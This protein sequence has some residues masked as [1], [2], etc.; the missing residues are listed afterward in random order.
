MDTKQFRLPS[1]SV[2]MMECPIGATFKDHFF[3]IPST[4]HPK[5][6][7]VHG[8]GLHFQAGLL[9]IIP[10]HPFHFL[11]SN[12][13]MVLITEFHNSFLSA[14]S[15]YIAFHVSTQIAI[16]L[17]GL[18]LVLLQNRALDSSCLLTDPTQSLLSTC[19]FRQENKLWKVSLTILLRQSSARRE[20]Y[21]FRI[22]I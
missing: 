5:S 14:F 18:P 20:K 3:S 10:A 6:P 19:L 22:P 9:Q 21:E 12:K 13:Q 7:G 16:S 15:I 17:F 11:N 2:S 8:N 4:H 1:P